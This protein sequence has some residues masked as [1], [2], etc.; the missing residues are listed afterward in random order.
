MGTP[1]DRADALRQ[2][3]APTL[4]GR[5]PV[6][7][8]ART[9][10]GKHRKSNEDAFFHDDELGLYIVADGMGGHAAGEV[11]SHQAVDTIHGMV[12]QGL[13]TLGPIDGELDE[14]QARAACR[15]M[16]GAIQ[17]ATYLI[18]A[19]AELERDKLGMGTTISAALLL[20]RSLVTGQVGDSRIYQIR[21]GAAVQLT[22]DHTLLAWQIKQGLLTPAEAAKATH[23]NVI[24]RAVG[25][26]DYVEVDTAVIPVRLGDRYLLCSD[27]L[28]GYLNTEEIPAIAETGGLDAVT[29][30]LDLA[31][32]RGGKDNITAVLVEL[33]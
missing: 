14:A 18:Y 22:E 20:G 19:M 28:H 27:G 25:N 31:N 33:V 2:N 7:S 24:T 6:R 29:R 32:G 30:F 3:E 17:A 4:R 23:K 15:I 5:W 16:E 26:R 10:V 21:D 1:H 12:K 8:A 11:A 9:D 13:G